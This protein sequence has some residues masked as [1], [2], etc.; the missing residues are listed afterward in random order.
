MA[1]RASDVDEFVE[2]VKELYDLDPVRVR[3][4][5]KY[6]HAEGTL[7]LRATN[8]E[9]WLTYTTDQVSDMRRLEALQLWLMSAMAGSDGDTLAAEAEA[10]EQA[11]AGDRGG[12]KR[13]G[14]KKAVKSK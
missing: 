2:K 10:A 6:K 4:V 14:R 9:I 3:F 11:A 5:M 8:D 13:K 12:G 1:Q 7:T